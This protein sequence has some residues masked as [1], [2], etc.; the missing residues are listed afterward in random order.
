MAYYRLAIPLEGIDHFML[1]LDGDGTPRRELGLSLSGDVLHA[2]ADDHPAEV[3][4][5]WHSSYGWEIEPFLEDAAPLTRTEFEEVWNRAD[6][7]V[8]GPRRE[9]S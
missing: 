5:I 1:E 6:P 7:P 3:K 9:L 8:P 4:C 2:A